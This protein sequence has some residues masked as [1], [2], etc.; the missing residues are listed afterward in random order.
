ME[1]SLHEIRKAKK[2]LVSIYVEE[3]F[4]SWYLLQSLWV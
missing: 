3:K 2:V 1:V 4:A